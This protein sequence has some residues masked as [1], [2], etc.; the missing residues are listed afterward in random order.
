MIIKHNTKSL[1]DMVISEIKSKKF[2]NSYDE[3]ISDYHPLMS[4]RENDEAPTESVVVMV[5]KST[6]GK[7][8][9]EWAYRVYVF[10]RDLGGTADVPCEAVYVTSDCNKTHLIARLKELQETYTC[11]YME[12]NSNKDTIIDENKKSKG[13]DRDCQ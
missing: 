2:T 8:R 6:D 11:K 10:Y 7:T 12:A 13:I 4:F 1:A 9:D 5:E 3:Y